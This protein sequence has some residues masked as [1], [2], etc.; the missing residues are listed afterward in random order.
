[1]GAEEKDQSGQKVYGEVEPAGRRDG[2]VSIKCCCWASA[3]RCF[4]AAGD[5][6][7]GP[8]A[9]G[10]R[11]TILPSSCESCGRRPLP[12]RRPLAP[13]RLIQRGPRVCK[14]T[15]VFRIRLSPG[16]FQ[17]LTPATPGLSPGCGGHARASQLMPPRIGERSDS[18]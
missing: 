11:T 5:E 13:A 7:P 9:S 2:V 15:S 8:T 18:I 12:E 1:M 17:T 4:S 3:G 10:W 16:S 14:L 6:V